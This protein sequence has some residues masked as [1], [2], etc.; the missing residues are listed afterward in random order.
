MDSGSTVSGWVRLD[1]SA[2]AGGGLQDS[3]SKDIDVC[4]SGRDL[5]VWED[6]GC[7]ICRDKTALCSVEF[8]SEPSL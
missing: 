2:E 8:S 7:L 5:D 4:E 6:A 3:V 1:A